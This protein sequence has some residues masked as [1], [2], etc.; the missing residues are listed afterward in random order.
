MITEP[1]IWNAIAPMI[2][3]TPS[4]ESGHRF[5][6]RWIDQEEHRRQARRNTDED[7]ASQARVRG[8]NSDL[9]LH[10]EAV[11]NDRRDVVEHFSQVAPRLALDHHSGDKEARVEERY[12][13][14]KL[15]QRVWKWPAEILLVEELLELG[16]NGGAHFLRYHLQPGSEGVTSLQ[17]ARNQRESFRQLLLEFPHAPLSLGA[18]E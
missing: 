13:A 5:Q 15:F 4:G 2:M 9:P 7:P 16:T 11:A 12:A 1:T 10:A 14:S 6:M 17:S 18:H 8:D 3:L